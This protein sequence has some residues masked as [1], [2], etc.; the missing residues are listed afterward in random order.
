MRF[1]RNI[2]AL[3]CLVALLAAG[4][5]AER[6]LGRG[7][8]FAVGAPLIP[9][10]PET[11]VGLS[12]DVEAP[13][14]ALREMTLRREGE[15][16][17]MGQPYPET[18][19][20]AAA[21]ADFLDALQG[22][23][24]QARLGPAEGS[25]FRA[26]RRL[27]VRTP[28]IAFARGFGGTQPMAL[29]QTLAE[30]DGT[31]VSVEAAAVARLPRTAATLRAQAILP[32]SP[33]RVVALEW[34][35]PGRPFARAQRLPGGNWEVSRPIPFEVEA[36]DAERALTLL[37][38][39]DTINAYVR[40]ADD[41]PFAPD[42]PLPETA[43][44]AYG[45][46]EEA[47]LRVSVYVR[48]LDDPL[49]LRFG[50]ADPARK[51]AVFCLLDDGRSVVSV[52][53][54]LPGCLGASGPFVAEFQ[55]FMV[56]GEALAAGADRLTVRLRGQ[57]TPV[58]LTWGGVGRARLTLPTA[59]PADEAITRDLFLGLTAFSGEVTGLEPPAGVE[60]L[61][62]VTVAQSD[63]STPPVTL[64]FY[65]AQEA[66]R[67]LAWR[68]DQGR[69]YRVARS[70]KLELLLSE[71]L[72]HRL[73]DRT[74]LS[75]PAGRI[76][77]IAVLRRDGAH[78]AAIRRGAALTWETESPA[79]AYVAT[80][81][82]DAWLTRFAD[83]KAGRVL[84]DA[85]V[86]PAELRPYG[87]DRPTTRLTLDLDGGADGLRRVLLIGDPDPKTGAAPAL[88]QGRPVLYELDAETVRLL[89]RWPMREGKE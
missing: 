80:E 38:R 19:C 6:F 66:D 86:S 43:L 33:D 70:P 71:G 39:A 56:L 16:W 5:V 68:A 63:G 53:A 4:L 40:P 76:R 7:T 57:E 88:V 42:R 87:L 69:L 1:V 45:L 36:H 28:E 12:W 21:V 3:L 51:G 32:V 27:V 65:P 31:L 60:P 89:S 23:R 35:G 83:L 73:A 26:V 79:G 47:A 55:E 48:G 74:V 77:R 18:L 54:S 44:D 17:R 82:L 11:V 85:P 72:Q 59:L 75:V 34:R 46:D 50:A 58:E 52:S 8:A 29:A 30:A 24:V 67:L 62:S 13:N 25:A 81:T 49:T 10:P 41:A 9:V 78:C 15:F 37:T 14:G 61:G 20:D 22:L 64:D 84:R 2:V